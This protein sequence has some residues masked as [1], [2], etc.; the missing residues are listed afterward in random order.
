M[1]FR[2][3]TEL[4]FGKIGRKTRS[5]R[6]QEIYS[7]LKRHNLSEKELAELW[8]YVAT[9][10]DHG[11]SA[12][13]LLAGVIGLVP[14]GIILFGG[15][16]LLDGGIVVGLIIAL[17][18][19]VILRYSSWR[20]YNQWRYTNDLITDL[21]N[22]PRSVPDTAVYNWLVEKTDFVSGQAYPEEAPI[23]R[24]DVLDEFEIDEDIEQRETSGPA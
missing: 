24:D 2:T 5:D 7:G 22:D 16:V 11:G 6:R 21:K 12:A 8:P 20:L 10:V 4:F 23:T 3:F 19:V 14:L 9:A 18:G 13:L 15:T 1:V 17:V